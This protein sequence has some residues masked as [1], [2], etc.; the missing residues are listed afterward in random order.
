MGGREGG[1]KTGR[2][3]GRWGGREEVDALFGI[4]KVIIITRLRKMAMRPITL[5]IAFSMMLR[6]TFEC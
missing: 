1:K 6:F 4:T 3:G 5:Q 2:E